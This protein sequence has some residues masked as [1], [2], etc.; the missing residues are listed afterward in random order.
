MRKYN[1]ITG[2]RTLSIRQMRRLLKIL[3]HEHLDCS[4]RPR[5]MLELWSKKGFD[6]AKIPF[7]ADVLDRW[8]R[9]DQSFG[10]ERRRLRVEAVTN[11]QKF[12]VTFASASLA[13]YVQAIVDHVLPLMQSKENLTRITRER[14][15]DAAKDGIIGMELRFAPQLHTWG[16]LSL[17]E[18]MDAVLE[19]AKDCPFA[20]KLIVCA[21][22][23]ENGDTAHK[24]ARLCI[25]YRRYVGLFDLAADEAANPGLLR[26]WLKAYLLLLVELEQKGIKQDMDC[27]N[28]LWETNNATD[29][30]IELL[31][32]LEGNRPDVLRTL[33]A[34]ALADA[35]MNFAGK[36]F[37]NL[38]DAI[39]RR[40]KRRKKR[41]GH[42]LRGNDRQ[43]KR[44]LELCP[45]SNH[46]TGQVA[47]FSDHPI[48]KF[49]REGK[50]VTVNTDGT[51][52]TEVQLSDEYRKLQE[53]F[54]W[55]LADFLRVNV[56]ALE[57]SSFSKSVKA[58]LRA[59]LSRTYSKI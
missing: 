41:V 3:I 47:K 1:E 50:L 6:Q 49:L 58:R 53:A 46:V 34:E 16:G 25:K 4:L 43:D 21:L 18:V 8:N 59:K 33:L 13:N 31:D 45:T 32:M 37:D 54:G 10:L 42:G 17:E 20:L 57:A 48:D 19:G 24:L 52:F 38:V 27:T 11:Y 28:H 15:E 39:Q 36:A 14:I 26:W 23:H 29:E 35:Q 2:T 22:R 55:T 44:V 7:P 5:T 9:A 51:L 30:D 40:L 12:L 56:T